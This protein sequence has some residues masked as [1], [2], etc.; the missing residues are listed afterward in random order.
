MIWGK[1][2]DDSRLIIVAHSMGCHLISTYIWDADKGRGIFEYEEVN[3]RNQLKNLNHLATIGC[4][5]PLFV[6]GLRENQITPF[7][8]RN[9]TFTWDNYFDPD[10]ILGWPL[11]QM[12]QKYND[13]VTDHEVNTGLYIGSHMRYW[14][15]SEFIIPL[16]KKANALFKEME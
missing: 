9:E 7:N 10:D 12:S 5:I 11:Q 4:N 14:N 2:F 15:D 3:E 1:T 8:K 16:A 6:S 13:L